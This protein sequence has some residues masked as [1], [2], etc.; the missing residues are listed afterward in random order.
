MGQVWTIVGTNSK[1]EVAVPV[2]ALNWWHVPAHYQIRQTPAH[3]AQSARLQHISLT[4]LTTWTLT[5]TALVWPMRQP[6]LK[7]AGTDN[8]TGYIRAC[9]QSRGTGELLAALFDFKQLL[10]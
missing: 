4:S 2:A 3:Q 1:R 8:G 10:G 5:T 6:P 9:G 7:V